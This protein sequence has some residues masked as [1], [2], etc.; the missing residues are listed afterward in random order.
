VISIRRK[1]QG[2]EIAVVDKATG[3]KSVVA[4]DYCI[5]TIPLTVLQKIPNDFSKDRQAAILRNG[6]YGDGYKIAF[7]S[8]RFWEDDQ[9][10]GGLSFTE[11]DTFI[12]WYPSAGFHQ[13][14]GI[15][16]AGY[17]FNGRMG[18]RSFADQVAYAR[19]TIDRL[20]PGKSGLMKSPIAVQWSK[21][22]YS[23]GLESEMANAN[24][25]DYTLLSDADGPF[26][27]AGEHLSH[28]GAW[29]QGA[30]VSAHRVVNLI[31]E[32]QKSIKG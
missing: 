26:Y 4:G 31:A 1:G 27:F 32:R 24:P 29:Q 17:A 10:Y 8:P 18:A 9:V 19:G 12:T 7:Q 28:V 5:C 15:I 14:E 23:F 11:R 13:P 25:A 22:P 16:I 2:V 3:T 21:M 30:F 20:H 6:T